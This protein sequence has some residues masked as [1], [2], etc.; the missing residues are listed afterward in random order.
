MNP[1]T[2][3]RIPALR[4]LLERLGALPQRTGLILVS[5]ILAIALA[6]DVFLGLS[7]G[8]AEPTY[9]AMVRARLWAPPP[10]PRI[11]IVDIDEASLEQMA[12]E[13]GRWPWSR[14]T[15]ATV[16]QHIESQHPAAIV[17]D[18][19]VTDADRN[20][21]GGDAAL[22]RAARASPNS[23]FPVIRLPA[24]GDGASVVTRAHL[25][26]LWADGGGGQGLAVVPPV[27][28]S[29]R[30]ARL[31]FNNVTPDADGIIRRY[32][33]FD[34]HGGGILKSMAMSVAEA[35]APQAYATALARVKRGG[36]QAGLIVWPA[37]GDRYPLLPFWQVFQQA[38]EGGPTSAFAGRIVVIGS[39][40]PSLHDVH[41]TPQSPHAPG[42][43]TL[44][45]AIDNAVH[46]RFV[47][48][49]T[50]AA[51]FAI[52]LGVCLL[53]VLV[54]HRR[55]VASLEPWLFL[56]PGLLLALSY[57]S[58]HTGWIFLDLQLAATWSL[59]LMAALRL[60][61][62]LRRSH[63]CALPQS[64]QGDLQLW[65]SRRAAAWDDRSVDGLIE[66]LQA[67]A[68]AARLVVHE[69]HDRWPTRAN[70]P[71]FSRLVAIVGARDD[72]ETAR[73]PLDAALRSMGA[74]PG[75]P[76]ALGAGATRESV[77]L[78]CLHG[79]ARLEPA[80]EDAARV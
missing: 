75:E 19:A 22:D 51:K 53:L 34:A 33:E 52:A 55:S 37:T 9:D 78:A 2:A 59:L 44:A 42:V 64:T 36:P 3:R 48:E 12:P 45:R 68:P 57:A 31:G 10:D 38:E 24:A 47:H 61:N 40:A 11:V 69:Q 15:L 73:E 56:L 23:H 20:S 25:P 8:L 35:V 14:D 32:R 54:A 66:A 43:A 46:A 49:L 1:A 28:Q 77:V 76:V 5:S 16:L 13:F 30:Q 26:R 50:G 60:W 74:T 70:W 18:I 27:L 79:W 71:E 17:W 62:G 65:P 29:L 63:W 72:L 41:P 4:W 39:T 6:A 7:A 21:P 80:L 67:H 58:L